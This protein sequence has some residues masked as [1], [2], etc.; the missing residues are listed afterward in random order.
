VNVLFNSTS[1][2]KHVCNALLSAM[3]VQTN[4]SVLLVLIHTLS[5]RKITSTIINKFQIAYRRYPAYL[6]IINFMSQI[7][8]FVLNVILNAKHA[9]DLTKNKFFNQIYNFVVSDM[10]TVFLFYHWVKFMYLALSWI[11]VVKLFKFHLLNM[12]TK[13]NKRL[14]LWHYF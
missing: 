8:I 12:P 5:S 6:Q 14:F 11:Y 2:P 13:T 1:Q 3:D 10:S 4:Y 9:S 7:R